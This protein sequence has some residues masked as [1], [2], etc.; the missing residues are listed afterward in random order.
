MYHSVLLL[1]LIPVSLARARLF[2]R[3]GWFNP[4]EIEYNLY[5]GHGKAIDISKMFILPPIDKIKPQQEEA[6][7][8]GEVVV[9]RRGAPGRPG[10][11][12]HHHPGMLDLEQ[13]YQSLK[14][15]SMFYDFDDNMDMEKD[16]LEDFPNENSI[17][18]KIQ[19]VSQIIKDYRRR[20][21]SRR[22]YV[23]CFGKCFTGWSDK[24][25]PDFND[26]THE[27]RKRVMLIDLIL[28]FLIHMRY[29]LKE[30]MPIRYL[31]RND[32]RYM[33]GYNF[34]RI[35]R[36]MYDMRKLFT[37]QVLLEEDKWQRNFITQVSVHKYFVHLE[38]DV[39]DT[40]ANILHIYWN[41]LEP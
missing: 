35:R 12:R 19:N 38:T 20:M 16:F 13:S 40:I 41:Q 7:V 14:E 18:E 11:V 32:K 37:S 22:T 34:N 21:T 39:R 26:W 3:P 30:A 8:E 25:D 28:A 9:E 10:L 6:S 36:L 17:V 2:P 1:L 27:N 4:W 5:Y 29:K 24:M 23:S 33:L 15:D 31:V